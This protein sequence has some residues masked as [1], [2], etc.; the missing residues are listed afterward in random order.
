M[1]FSPCMTSAKQHIVALKKKKKKPYL[2]FEC[3]YFSRMTTKYRIGN[4][5]KKKKKAFGPKAFSMMVCIFYECLYGFHAIILEYF[6]VCN[7]CMS[8]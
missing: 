7:S 5:L 1:Y 6:G 4:T 8:I 3:I 2:I